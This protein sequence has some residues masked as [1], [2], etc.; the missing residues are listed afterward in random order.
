M[1][2]HNVNNIVITATYDTAGIYRKL[3]N[4]KVT[5]F[6]NRETWTFLGN[7]LCFA[8]RKSRKHTLI[9]IRRWQF[10]FFQFVSYRSLLVGRH[11]SLNML[12]GD[13]T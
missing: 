4:Y 12:V 6:P 7:R 11:N 8:I 3:P 2:M 13:M 10:S 9:A 1:V 5:S